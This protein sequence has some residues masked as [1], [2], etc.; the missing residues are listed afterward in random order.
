MIQNTISNTSN[1]GLHCQL[2]KLFHSTNEKRHSNHK[3]PKIWCNFQRFAT[4][5][6]FKRS[7]K[8]LRRFVNEFHESKWIQ[9]LGF[10]ELPAKST[11]HDWYKS[12]DLRPILRAHTRILRKQVKL[13]SVDGTGVDSWQRS[14]HYA[15]RIGEPQMPYAKLDILIDI[16]SKVILDHSLRIKNRHDVIAAEQMLKRTPFKGV[17]LA[18]KGYDSE[19]LHEIARKNGI[20]LKA[21]VRNSERKRPRGRYRRQCAKGIENYSMRNTVESVIHSLKSVYVPNLRS[22]LWFMK[23]KEMGLAILVYNVEKMMTQSVRKI[24]ILIR[25]LFYSPD[26]PSIT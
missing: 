26:T 24:L 21:P 22:R 16:E 4:L 14:R 7:G 19:P 11:I 23:K 20:E 10:A 13:L 15:R 6:L 8:S 3:G 25:I 2:L 18:D 9:W 5:F 17:C 12:A 1:I